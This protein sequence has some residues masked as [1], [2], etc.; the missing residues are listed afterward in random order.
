LGPSGCGKSTILRLI[1]GLEQATRGEILIEAQR[2]DH[3]APRE[4]DIAF[5]FQS[6]A[7]YP[8]MTA[9]EN[10][11]FSLRLR[12][13]P[14]TEIESKVRDAARLLEIEN[15][16]QRRPQELSGGQR[17]RVAL[18]RAIVRQPKIFLFDEPLSNLDAALRATM[19]VEL[20]RLHRRLHATI[21]YVTHD[22]AEA[23]TLGDKL[24]VLHHGSIQQIGPPSDIYHKPANTLV[25]SFVGSPQINLLEGKLDETGSNLHRG[26]LRLDLSS[27]LKRSLPQL[28]GSSVTLGIR[29]EDW[30]PVD[31]GQAWIRGE[32]ELVEDLG[33]DR[34][35]HLKCDRMDLIARAE[36]ETTFRVGDTIGLKVSAGGMHLFQDGK[37][38]DL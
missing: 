32:V 35:V 17:Q 31:A 24:I 13:A 22:Q 23:L 5:V 30:Q 12:G 6:Y 34:F 16:L 21:V 33:S 14:A 15:L 25:A 3:L 27:V 1:A 11:A 28:A 9:F 29:A 36:R 2:V 4:R 37:R 7:L 20:T 19:R 8:H 10:L 18:G 26:S 38:I